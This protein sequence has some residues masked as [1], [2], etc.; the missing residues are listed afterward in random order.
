MGHITKLAICAAKRGDWFYHCRPSL[1]F[2]VTSV[3][4]YWVIEGLLMRPKINLECICSGIK[5]GRIGK[6]V[7]CIPLIHCHRPN[8]NAVQGTRISA[9]MASDVVIYKVATGKTLQRD[10]MAGLGKPLWWKP[11]VYLA[12]P[13]QRFN[14]PLLHTFRHFVAHVFA[15]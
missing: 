3:G 2:K 11:C 9:H 7:Q 13:K 5:T 14:P 10:H 12:L 8:I 15:K 4:W 6:K 1:Y